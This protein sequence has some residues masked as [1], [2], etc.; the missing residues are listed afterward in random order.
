MTDDTRAVSATGLLATF[1]AAGALTWSDVHPA[2][3]WGYLFGEADPRVLLAAALTVRAL[4]LGSI[5]L[6]LDRLR[7]LDQWEDA[8]ELDPSWWPEQTAWEEALRR[9]PAVT[10]GSQGAPARPLR[11]VDGAL[12]LERHYADQEVVRR[13]MLARLTTAPSGGTPQGQQDAVE[14]AVTSPVTVIAG[15]PGTGKTW[16]IRAVMAR[17]RAERPDALVALA[18]PT[19]KAAAR[20]TE[21]LGDPAARAVT[22]H[23]LLGWRR[24]S[25]TRFA[26]DATRPLPHDV[27]IIDEMSMV[28]M[29]LMARLLEA[30]KPGARLVLVG[31]PDQLSSVDAGSVLA[32]ITSAP[33][34]AGIVA[35]LSH[36][37]RFQGA[38]ATLAN[39]IRTG[40]A[41]LAL[42]TLSGGESGVRLADGEDGLTA[43]R[44]Q[45]VAAGRRVAEA[46]AAA[47][48][49]AALEALD[50]HRL[51]CGHRTGPF[52]VAQWSRHAVAWLSAEVPGFVADGDAYPG[53]PVMMTVNRPE[54]GLYNGD[55]GVVLSTGEAPQAWFGVAGRPRP[56]SPYVL[57]GLTSVH[58]MTVH[59]AQGSQFR[60][61]SVILPP[62]GSPLLTRELLYTAVSRARE[63]VLLLGDE[64]A[65]AQAIARPARRMS[66]LA[67]RLG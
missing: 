19:G 23:A 18:A 11:L 37:F 44:A 1:N 58:A 7:E 28:S 32:D 65:V 29:A 36:N 30:L 10:L 14:L 17:I 52:G 38:I 50:T 2:Q 48:P 31:D 47:D 4:R 61:V 27:V 42:T 33:A 25:R 67:A 15:G 6:P 41:D 55:T 20:M 66:G 51:L 46:V 35:R 56:F 5:C 62:A 26:H 13:E 39:A 49:A 8:V 12:Y 9:S 54:L 53:R 34:S 24:G 43:A 63:S 16:T 22:L 59:K 3:Q 64:A 40:D 45:V 57:D 60:H 21:S